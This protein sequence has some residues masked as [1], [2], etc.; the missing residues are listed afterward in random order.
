[1]SPHAFGVFLQGSVVDAAPHAACSGVADPRES[2]AVGVYYAVEHFRHVSSDYLEFGEL[3]S[4]LEIRSYRDCLVDSTQEYPRS[5]SE[6]V[7]LEE[8]V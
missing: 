6:P 8:R 2:F 4:Y 1:M 7:L 5:S 3:R